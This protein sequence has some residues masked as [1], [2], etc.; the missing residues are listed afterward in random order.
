MKTFLSTTMLISTLTL[1]S[2]NAQ[3]TDPV[4]PDAPAVTSPAMPDTGTGATPMTPETPTETMP[5]TP[6]APA[7]TTAPALPD[8]AAPDGFVRQNVVLT[9]KDLLGAAIYDINGKSIGEVRDL[10]LGGDVG[11]KAEAGAMAGSTTAGTAAGAAMNDAPGAVTSPSDA[12]KGQLTHAVLDV[13][14]FLGLGQHRVAV[15]VSDLAVYRSDTE[16]RV[17]LPWSEEQLKAAPAYDRDDPSTLG[18]P[19]MSGQ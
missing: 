9:A 11:T 17:Y 3:T 5:A 13:G 12:D 1:M 8:I 18:R 7:A 16:T 10:V 6:E 19:L 14:G 4:A 15:P 2:A